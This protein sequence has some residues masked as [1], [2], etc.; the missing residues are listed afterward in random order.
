VQVAEIPRWV[1]ERVA[2]EES[3]TTSTL[4]PEKQARRNNLEPDQ[5]P[6][7]LEAVPLSSPVTPF[8]HPDSL[9]LEDR[10]RE[11]DD[12]RLEGT[13]RLF[14]QIGIS[15]GL[16]PPMAVLPF[17]SDV[18][19]AS[20]DPQ[21]VPSTPVLGPQHDTN[22]QDLP[23]S[24]PTVASVSRKRSRESSLSAQRRFSEPQIPSSPPESPR[25]SST[26]IS[27]ESQIAPPEPLETLPDGDYLREYNTPL[28]QGRQTSESVQ[29]S[30]FATS[31]TQ[32]SL[33]DVFAPATQAL[34]SGA[35]R[36]LR[37]RRSTRTSDGEVEEQ[38]LLDNRQIQSLDL[39][40]ENIDPDNAMDITMHEV[41]DPV[42]HDKQT[43]MTQTSNPDSSQTPDQILADLS[44]GSFET[45][46]ETD[47]DSQHQDTNM[48]PN[49]YEK[50]KEVRLTR[51]Q[52]KR[53]AEEEKSS[54][55]TRRETRASRLESSRDS[56]DQEVLDT[57]ISFRSRRSRKSGV[58]DPE[59]IIES[60]GSASQSQ[61]TIEPSQTRKDALFSASGR[62]GSS[63][64]WV[65][66]PPEDPASCFDE[67]DFEGEIEVILN[68]EHSEHR[69]EQEHASPDFS[70]ECDD[71]RPSISQIESPIP[72]TPSQSSSP[73][74]TSEEDLLQ[75]GNL[76]NITGTAQH[77]ESQ[78][79]DTH[80]R[81]QRV[82][83]GSMED[84]L[85]RRGSK[86]KRKQVQDSYTEDAPRCK[87]RKMNSGDMA[88]SLTSN[89]SDV[90]SHLQAKDFETAQ[91]TLPLT[92]EE[93][94]QEE[95]EVEEL[96][97]DQSSDN[98]WCSTP[99]PISETDRASA[100][101]Q[102][103]A[104]Q[105]RTPKVIIDSLRELMDCAS[106]TPFS[107]DETREVNNILFEFQAAIHGY[108]KKPRI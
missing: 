57:A 106:A 103:T 30:L 69:L 84:N 38:K 73:S 67:G 29:N 65:P 41:G 72:Q 37:N 7:L 80:S 70:P 89:A 85:S 97:E 82:L 68:E 9:V 13:S 2:E 102:E 42:E 98:D 108:E 8:T 81:L 94:E 46:S 16:K 93:E 34:S 12:G 5:S 83:R 48:V 56:L 99:P 58:I 50:P 52:R 76:A 55:P 40:K 53:R 32:N 105:T 6:L 96:E 36:Q 21:D 64:T 78:H 87:M 59:S 19:V 22:D 71:A 3:M 60:R 107:L 49:K 104:R 26:S 101:V 74:T 86:M 100:S 54:Q 92:R 91:P 27:A 11:V 39:N 4:T 35:L 43:Q 95:E 10:Q 88:P 18:I 77:P 79:Q 33:D 75:K 51:S 24:S 45:V 66:V 47:A 23:L 17:D 25:K 63:K 15:S 31:K 14:P 28:L 90:S 61:S 20:S 62:R 1:Q 44:N